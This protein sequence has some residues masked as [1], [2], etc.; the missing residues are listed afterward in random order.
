MN[1]MLENSH[2]APR[3]QR[4]FFFLALA[5]LAMLMVIG[6]LLAKRFVLNTAISKGMGTPVSPLPGMLFSGLA[7]SAPIQSAFLLSLLPFSWFRRVAIACAW[8][9]VVVLAFVVGNRAHPFHDSPTMFK[10]NALCILPLVAFAGSY[11]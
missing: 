2:T 9:I 7:F 1:E 5:S 4:V 3:N 11:R 6:C 8:M 10:S